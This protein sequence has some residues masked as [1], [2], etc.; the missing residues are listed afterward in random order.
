MDTDVENAFYVHNRHDG[1][2]MKYKR[3]PRTNLY[4][5]AI[6]EG[7]ENDVLIHSI[8]EGESDRFSQIAQTLSKAVRKMQQVLAS[9]SDYD[10]ANA[11]ENNVFGSTL[12]IR[13]TV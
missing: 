5:Y 4:T 8:V 7:K 12:F 2:Y 11:I 13:R 3:C 1:S 6:E 9:P 10:L